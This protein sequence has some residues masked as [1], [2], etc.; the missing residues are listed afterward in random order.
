[1]AKSEQETTALKVAMDHWREVVG[2]SCKPASGP[3]GKGYDL[4]C[5][6][7]HVELKGT[8]KSRPGFRILTSGEFDAA[9]KD[10]LFEL[11]IVSDIHEGKGSLH[12]VG[13]EDVLSSAIPVLHWRLPLGTRRLSGYRRA[14]ITNRSRGRQA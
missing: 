9:R 14:R 3:K 2:C 7:R 4:G 12:I 1:M 8:K 13:R 11:W 10:P 5:D 6:H